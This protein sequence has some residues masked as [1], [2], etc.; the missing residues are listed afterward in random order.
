VYSE[1]VSFRRVLRD[2]E[3]AENEVMQRAYL[4]DLG[5]ED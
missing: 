1:F 5:G 2:H 3:Q 4:E